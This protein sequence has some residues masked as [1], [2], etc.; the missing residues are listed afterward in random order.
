VLVQANYGRR[1]LLRIDGVPV[2]EEIPE[3][4]VPS[5]WSEPRAARRAA[6]AAALDRGPGAGSIILVVATDAPLLPHQCERLARRS[7]FGVARVG[8]MGSPSS[9]DIAICF[10][11]GNRGLP[12]PEAEPVGGGVLG[13]R[14][15]MDRALGD[16]FEATVEATEEAIANALVAAETMTGRDGNVAHRLPHER[17]A[18]VMAR[19]GRHNRR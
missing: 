12:A 9:G 8:G 14:T 15:V 10:A 7:H 16:L 4:E 13:I 18:E 17:L 5:P 2:G 6:A 3:S 19:H 1:G 11:T